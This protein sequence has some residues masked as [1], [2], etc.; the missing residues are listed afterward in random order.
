[1]LLTWIISLVPVAEVFVM[2]AYGVNLL[3]L[4]MAIA[5]GLGAV[6]GLYPAWRA[7]RLRPIEALQYE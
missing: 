4:A 1:L 5:M 2:P 6:G 3:A 7:T